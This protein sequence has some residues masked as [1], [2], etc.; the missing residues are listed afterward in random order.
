VVKNNDYKRKLTCD[1]CKKGAL[2][3]I[4]GAKRIDDIEIYWVCRHCDK[5]VRTETEVAW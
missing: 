1:G 3:T 2:L 5:M 4:S